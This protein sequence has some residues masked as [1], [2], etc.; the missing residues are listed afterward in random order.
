MI[1]QAV[2]FQFHI[3]M[4][5]LRVFLSV[6]VGTLFQ[7]HIGMINPSTGA[8]AR[9]GKPAFQFHIGMINPKNIRYYDTKGSISIP[10][11]YD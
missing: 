3:G 4:I 11:W 2:P 6:S 8:G 9:G 5:N 7:F 1:L 10:H